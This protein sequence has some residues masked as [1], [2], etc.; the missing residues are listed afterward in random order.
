MEAVGPGEL[1]GRVDEGFS[2][3]GLTRHEPENGRVGPAPA[4]GEKGLHVGVLLLDCLGEGGENGCVSGFDG[5]S[6]GLRVEI[7]KGA[8]EVSEES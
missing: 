8:E 2:R 7:C 3:T 6:V 4:D 1:D 5:D